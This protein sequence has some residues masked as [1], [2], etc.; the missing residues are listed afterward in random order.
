[1]LVTSVFDNGTYR[2]QAGQHVMFERGNLHE[3]ID[4]EKEPCGCPPDAPKGN[5][6]PLAQSE[7][8]AP[9]PKP[10]PAQAPAVSLEHP[11]PATTIEPLVYNSTA[12]TPQAVPAP[13]AAAPA[14]SDAGTA[15]AAPKPVEKKK[16]GF[17]G[18]IRRFFR[19]IFGAE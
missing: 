15:A 18:G 14:T 17:F 1:M 2:V 10:V 8:L 7:G 19:K 5:E 12:H 13:A 4:Q 9:T 3:V 6:F 16:G 11:G